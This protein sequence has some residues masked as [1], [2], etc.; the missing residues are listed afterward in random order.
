MKILQLINAPANSYVTYKSED[1][2]ISKELIVCLGLIEEDGITSILPF[3]G[4]N[5]NGF[6][7]PADA[8]AD[9]IVEVTW[10]EQHKQ[11]C[12]YKG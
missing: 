6:I 9:E 11:M 3:I 5:D 10:N 4:A 2:Y 7:D 1:G 12:K 8:F